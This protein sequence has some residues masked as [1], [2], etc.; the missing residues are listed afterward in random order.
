[1]FYIWIHEFR[2]IKLLLLCILNKVRVPEVYKKYE[3]GFIY[4]VI[5]MKL[6]CCLSL[7]LKT[8]VVFYA[9]M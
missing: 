1:M 5:L 2:S 7:H 3:E 4:F 9:I 8:L 6:N